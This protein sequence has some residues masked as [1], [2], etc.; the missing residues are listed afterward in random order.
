MGG[1]GGGIGISHPGGI[2]G[3][4]GNMT[5]SHSGPMGS[6]GRPQVSPFPSVTNP[7]TMYPSHPL[8]SIRMSTTCGLSFTHVLFVHHTSSF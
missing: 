2:T 6:M 7:A 5:M 8:W 3:G 1:G 4:M